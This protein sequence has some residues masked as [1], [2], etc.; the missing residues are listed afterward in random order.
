MIGLL[1][2]RRIFKHLQDGD[3]R[4]CTLSTEQTIRFCDNGL[5]A[6]RD[7]KML[8]LT[9]LSPPVGMIFFGI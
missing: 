9:S 8:N 6:S 4:L 2:E 7:G 5:Y 3:T 1:M